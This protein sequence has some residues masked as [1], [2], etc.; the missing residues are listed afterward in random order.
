[1]AGAGSR[2]RRTTTTLL[3]C[4]AVAACQGGAPSAE[5]PTTTGQSEAVAVA[6]RP[7][8][9]AG[10]MALAL[11]PALVSVGETACTP[12]R[13]RVCSSDGTQGWVP[14]TDPGR[15][16]LVEAVARLADEHTSWTTV[17]RFDRAS[18]PALTRAAA[19]AAAVGGVVLLISDG[20]A[21]AAVAPLE[22]DGVRA[23]FTGLTKPEAWDLVAAFGPGHGR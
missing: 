18:G 1:M 16:T 4:V 3:T 15:A 17:L 13:N 20:R 22:L 23:T 10:R 8:H 21:R 12:A 11:Q 6:P 5:P 19:D 7:P 9:F 2:I 14:I